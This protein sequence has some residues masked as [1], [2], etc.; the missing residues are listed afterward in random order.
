MGACEHG[1]VTSVSIKRGK[2][3]DCLRARFLK[4]G[5]SHA[6][7]LRNGLVGCLDGVT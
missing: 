6:V 3:L 4:K 1:N 2:F 5:L 7:S